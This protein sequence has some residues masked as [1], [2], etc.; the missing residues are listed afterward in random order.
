MN[1]GLTIGSFALIWFTL[2]CTSLG[3]IFLKLGLGKDKI[4]VGENPL[5][6]LT[7]IVSRMMTVKIIIGL[8][9][10]AVGAFSWLMVLS[11]VPLSIAYPMFSMSYFLV[12]GLAA[13]VLK[14]KVNWRFAITG[15]ILISIGVSLVGL[16]NPK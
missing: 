6:T 11:R 2:F 7:N 1:S 8:L 10:Y 5:K 9:L 13:L 14:E 15:L 16:S 4:P 12:V 3:Q